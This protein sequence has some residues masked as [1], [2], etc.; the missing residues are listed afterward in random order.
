[1][2]PSR[3]S[4]PLVVRRGRRGRSARWR[5]L[6]IPVRGRNLLL[7]TDRGTAGWHSSDRIPAVNMTGSTACALEAHIARRRRV[8]NATAQTRRTGRAEARPPSQIRGSA[9]VK[10][11]HHAFSNDCAIGL[12]N[13]QSKERSISKTRSGARCLDGDAETADVCPAQA[14]QSSASSGPPS[15]ASVKSKPVTSL[16]RPRNQTGTPRCPAPPQGKRLSVSGG[17]RTTRGRRRCHRASR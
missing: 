4:R 11:T 17:S 13:P 9:A 5:S 14:L 16:T 3:R 12:R 6:C 8:V 7:G 10:G 15:V 1:M 2:P